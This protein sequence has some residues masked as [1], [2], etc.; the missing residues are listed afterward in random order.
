[1]SESVSVR[2]GLKPI[3]SPDPAQAHS[4]E[5]PGKLRLIDGGCSVGSENQRDIRKPIEN[6]PDRT[7][8]LVHLREVGGLLPGRRPHMTLPKARDPIYRRRWFESDTIELCV[9]V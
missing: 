5:R 6:V 7:S 3:A 8:V 4:F 9:R 1:M 2:A